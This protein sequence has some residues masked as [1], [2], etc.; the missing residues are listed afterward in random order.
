MSATP[1]RARLADLLFV[2][3][4]LSAIAMTGLTA[5]RQFRPTGAAAQSRTQAGPPVP[6]TGWDTLQRSGHRFGAT[7]PTTT[8]VVFGDFECP[9]C[10]RF[11]TTTLAEL[12][13]KYPDD[14]AIVFRHWALSYHRFAMPAARAAECAAAQ[15]RFEAFHDRLFAQQ[16][17]LGIKRFDAFARESGVPDAEAFAACL[18]RTDTLPVVSAG[19]RTAKAMQAT[20]TPTV[21]VNG[22][23]YPLIPTTAELAKVIEAARR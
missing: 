11:A 23:R 22:L 3:A 13:A 17:S 9:A 16:D 6:V 19:A 14:L 21:V 10:R 1:L 4:A 8:M 7:A 5:W 15:G 2:G 20:G 12:R 18:A